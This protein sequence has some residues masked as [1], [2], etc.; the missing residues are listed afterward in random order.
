MKLQTERMIAQKD[1]AIGWITFNNPARHNAVSLPMWQGLF[2]A[3]TAFAEDDEVRV[4][5]LKGAGDKAFVSGADISEFEEKRSNAENIAAYN[6]VSHAATAAL[7]DVNKPTIAMIRGYCVGGGV[8]VALSCD[9]RI[10]AQGSS[11][12]VPAAKLG[13]GYEFEGVRKLVDVV[14]PSFAREIFYTA[15]QFTVEE[16]VTMGLVNRVVPVDELEAFVR[17]YAER[18]A[19]NA[20]LT[21]A[22]IKT[23]VAQTLKDESERNVALCKAVVDRC[24]ASADYVEGRQAFMEKRKPKFT[25]R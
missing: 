24:F 9:L 22:S 2:D 6:A 18:I 13:L 7:H 17:G 23:L 8:S 5:V 3:V 4:I 12:A 14:G 1:G 11:F 10:A 25:G 20:P 19:A 16:A 15:R 21:V